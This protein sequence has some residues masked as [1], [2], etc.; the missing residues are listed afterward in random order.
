VI[1]DKHTL[2]VA[3]H[4]QH[5]KVFVKFALEFHLQSVRQV[6]IVRKLNVNLG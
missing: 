6:L 2:E 1:P 4:A 5:L 3:A